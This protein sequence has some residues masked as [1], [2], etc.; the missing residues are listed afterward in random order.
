MLSEKIVN[1]FKHLFP[2][3]KD[4]FI[5]LHEPSFQGNEWKYVKE[6][7]DSTFVSSV[8]KFVDDFEIQIAK[9]TGSKFAIA[10]VNGTS[11]LHISLL[12]AGVKPNDEVLIPTLSF[13]A[14]ANAVSYIGATPHFLDSE[15][16][17][18]GI[19]P[20][21]IYSYLKEIVL[22]QSDIPI[23]K[24]TGKRISAIV[25]MHTFGHPVNMEGISR[26]SKDFRITIVED[27]AESLG[28]YYQNKHTGTIGKLGVLSFNGNK[29]ITT[30]GGGVILTQDEELAKKAKHLTTTAKLSHKWEY[31]H[32]QIGYNYRMPNL[33]AAI[34]LAQLENL[35]NFLE[36]KR[37]LY[38]V[39]SQAFSSFKEFIIQKEPENSKSNYWLQTLVLEKEFE[40][41]R[42]L[43]LEE[44]NASGIM[45]RPSWTLL[46]KL[47]PF[48]NSPKMNLITAES[49]EKRIINI[50]SSSNLG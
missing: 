24:I 14:T 2:N 16:S 17:T 26:I 40:N 39:Y 18:L 23:N 25:P 11:A 4:S 30:G 8:G 5:P 34:G 44:T 22:L 36:N 37:S 42:D 43:I 47:K 33:N 45:T 46:H 48:E 13:V 6:C 3:K 28:S 21:A 50:P 19:Y 29:T 31:T 10:T 38:L 49:L 35:P 1:T 32:D 7:I 20:D 15:E 27:S 12:L 9:F 41:Q